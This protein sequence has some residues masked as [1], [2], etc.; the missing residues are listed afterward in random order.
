MMGIVLT[1]VYLLPRVLIF[2]LSQCCVCEFK[3]LHYHTNENKHDVAK[4]DDRYL[5]NGSK[6]R[7]KGRQ[8]LGY[9]AVIS[10]MHSLN[11]E[12]AI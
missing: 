8:K 12:C 1:H 3:Y 2:V 6:C 4:C 7:N 9:L 5:A 10:K 11:R